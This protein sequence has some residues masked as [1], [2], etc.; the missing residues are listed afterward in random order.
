MNINNEWLVEN[1]A[2]TAGKTWFLGQSE[3]DAVKVVKALI[4]EDKLVW[5]NWLISRALNRKDRIGYVVYAA[6]QVINIYDGKHP[7]NERRRNAINSA[8]AVME[9]PSKENKDA[10]YAAYAAAYAYADDDAADSADAYA[11]SAAAYAAYA[12]AY[13]YADDDAYDDAYTDS[14]VSAAAHAAAYAAAYAYADDDDDD[15]AYAA[16]AAHALRIK[17]LR[18]GIS[19]LSGEGDLGPATGKEAL[20]RRDPET[21]QEA[22][23]DGLQGPRLFSRRFRPRR[24][25]G[26]EGI[27]PEPGL[28]PRYDD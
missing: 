7:G 20:Q 3:S 28:R 23:H 26:V 10:A 15:D 4:K 17:I 9:N 27:L 6:E 21:V 22:V 19:L 2:C 14:A 8:K 12:A 16:S 1:D 11:A 5:A 18:Y 25:P 24:T 13:A